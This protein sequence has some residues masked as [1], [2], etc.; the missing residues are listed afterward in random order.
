MEGRDEFITEVSEAQEKLNRL[1]MKACQYQLKCALELNDPC[2]FEGDSRRVIGITITDAAPL[3][4][5]DGV[6]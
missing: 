3:Y 1:L 2:V 5:S 4:K 6:P